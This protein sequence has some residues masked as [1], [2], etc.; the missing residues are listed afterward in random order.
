MPEQTQLTPQ[1]ITGT[2][3]ADAIVQ[4]APAVAPTTKAPAVPT[5]PVSD[6]VSVSVPNKNS[7]SKGIIVVAASLLVLTIIGIAAWYLYSNNMLL[8]NQKGAGAP[9]VLEAE[10]LMPSGN[11]V[12]A[13]EEETILTAPEDINSVEELAQELDNIWND[14]KTLDQIDSELNSP[15]VD[16]EL[17]L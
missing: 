10:E 17:G 9:V 5:P 16:L 12:P 4:N 3:V 11:T 14:L 2:T 8:P 13:I 15:E 6:N 1:P 7:K